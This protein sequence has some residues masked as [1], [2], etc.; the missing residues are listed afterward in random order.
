MPDVLHCAPVATYHI[1]S[2]DDPR[3]APYRNLP[4]RALSRDGDRF[5]A[6]GRLVV[7]RL[8]E[9]DVP[10]E[11]VLVG[12]K[13]EAEWSAIMHDEVPLYVV[14]DA[15]VR[16]VVGFKFHAGALA[17]G[18]RPPSPT[19]DDLFKDDPQRVTLVVCPKIY[20][21]ENIGS[22]VRT[23]AGFGVTGLILGEQ[24]HNPFYRMSVRVSMGAVFTLP[25]VRCE[26]IT[27]DLQRLQEH[28]QAQLAA[29]VAAADAEPLAQA[30]RPDRFALLFGNEAEGLDDPHLAMCDRRITIPMQLGTDSLNVAVAA[31]VF[32]YH[33]TP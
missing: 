19:I 4:D 28:H 21:N 23:C 33:F 10:A 30:S 32:L 13:H 6:E 27:A 3:L 14:P 18:T 25:I 31:A 24:C 12:D 1:D 15:L 22:I 20:G 26:D 5:I 16:D 11:S 7:R 8:L 17:C 9:S 2:L 29:T